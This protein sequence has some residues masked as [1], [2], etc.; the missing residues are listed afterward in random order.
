MTEDEAKTKACPMYKVQ[1]VRTGIDTY[2]QHRPTC[3]GSDCMMWRR[4]HPAEGAMD[5][6]YC[7]LAGTPQ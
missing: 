3:I 2:V 5:H 1:E 6:G 4:T 7:G